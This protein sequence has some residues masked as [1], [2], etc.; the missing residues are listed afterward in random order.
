LDPVMGATEKYRMDVVAQIDA[1]AGAAS[2]PRR[3]CE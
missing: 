3:P 2:L 1:R